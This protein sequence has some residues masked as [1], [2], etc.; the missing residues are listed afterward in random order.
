MEYTF[1]NAIFVIFLA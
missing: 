1:P